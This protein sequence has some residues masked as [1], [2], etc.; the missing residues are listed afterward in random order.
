M[1]LLAIGV[2]AGVFSALFGVG[3]GIIVVP[4]LVLALGYG[5]RPATGT[6]L[7]ALS[8]TAAAGAVAYSLHGDLKPGAAA[9][10]GL[11]AVF[12]VVAG[13]G[14]QQRLA[15]RTLTLGFAALL[16]AVGVRLLV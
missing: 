3:G 14:L 15:T 10:V 11:P 8:I 9:I 13:V 16:A 1:R 12:G 6:S 7:A 5:T 4:M 2:A